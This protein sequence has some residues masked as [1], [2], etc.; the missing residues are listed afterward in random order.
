MTTDDRA[1]TFGEALRSARE[2]AGMDLMTLSKKTKVSMHVLRSIEVAD[3]GKLPNPAFVRG[4]VRLYAGMV[5][6]DEAQALRGY[7]ESLSAYE[8]SI[9][10]SKAQGIRFSPVMMA[11]VAVLAGV[12]GLM[13]YVISGVGLER[14]DDMGGAFLEGKPPSV[15]EA[16]MPV[17]VGSADANR[18]TMNRL[19]V[20]TI[21]ET[22]LKVIIDDQPSKT[23][24]L[25]PGDRLELE[26]ASRFNLLVGSA[27]GVRLSLNGTAV[28]IAGRKNQ[29][30]TLKLP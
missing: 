21:E 27:S 1:S 28:R 19:T 7:Q 2:A 25:N 5:G 29:P 26:A 3:H 12:V 8:K 10:V 11:S 30:V 13:M 22:W 15:P 17:I 18:A 4:F 6:L 9:T 24:N 20:A 16:A 14:S 23:Y